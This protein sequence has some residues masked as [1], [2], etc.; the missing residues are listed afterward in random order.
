MTSVIT[1]LS[2]TPLSLKRNDDTRVHIEHLYR[3]DNLL[4]EIEENYDSDS[5]RKLAK[6]CLE[7]YNLRIGEI[8]KINDCHQCMYS[9]DATLLYQLCGIEIDNNSNNNDN[10]IVFKKTSISPTPSISHL[11]K[12]HTNKKLDSNDLNKKMVT[13][14]KIKSLFKIAGDSTTIDKNT[15]TDKNT[16]K[17]TDTNTDNNNEIDNDDNDD[18][19]TRKLVLAAWNENNRDDKRL[20]STSS[21]K[22]WIKYCTRYINN[23]HLH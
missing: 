16:N 6:I 7:L 14:N 18:A 2:T 20:L 10:I 19:A 4:S 12:D 23:Y 13:E 17:S 1:S 22:L 15:N 21:H 5:R 8:I 3:I 9:N 11:L